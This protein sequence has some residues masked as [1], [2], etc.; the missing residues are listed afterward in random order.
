MHKQ[1]GVQDID[2]RRE[3][4]LKVVIHSPY[5]LLILLYK[6]EGSEK[7]NHLFLRRRPCRFTAFRLTAVLERVNAQKEGVVSA[8]G[9][10]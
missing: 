5:P 10:G 9:G 3:F 2:I 1:K 7:L 6:K 4:L 8:P